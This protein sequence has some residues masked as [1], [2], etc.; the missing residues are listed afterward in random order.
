MFIPTHK[1]LTRLYYELA[2]LGVRLTGR[3]EK[4]IQKLDDQESTIALACDWSRFDAR[5]FEALVQYFILSWQQINP[6]LLRQKYKTMHTPQTICLIA[7]FGRM[8]LKAD[9]EFKAYLSYLSSQVRPVTPQLYFHFLFTPAGQLMQQTLDGSLL[10]YTQWGFISNFRPILDTLNR[11]TGGHHSKDKRL[12]LA[13]QILSQEGKLALN[14]YLQA[15]DYSVSRQQALLDLKDL[16]G[17]QC[18]GHGRG[19]Y[20]VY[21]D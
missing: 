18:V 17:L 11:T 10:E 4:W 15:L 2:L 3:K 1:D 21:R 5:L 6:T 19:S 9:S 7:S 20:W 16:K 14:Q 13:K 12:L 8:V